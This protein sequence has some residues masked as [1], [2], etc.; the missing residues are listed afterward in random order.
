MEA[1]NSTISITTLNVNGLNS[2]TKRH[3][4]PNW[5]KKQDSTIFD[6]KSTNGLRV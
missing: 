6:L 1:V 5:I 4:L 2:L 3:I